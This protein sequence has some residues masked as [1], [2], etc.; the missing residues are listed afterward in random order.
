M[1]DF[2]TTAA[3]HACRV[4]SVFF[5]LHSF[6]CVEFTMIR[7]VSY[8]LFQACPEIH[9]ERVA[10]DRSCFAKGCGLRHAPPS[11]RRLMALSN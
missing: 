11:T 8:M 2:R 5:S 1:T 7:P 3:V 4:Q 9:L 6:S 10:S